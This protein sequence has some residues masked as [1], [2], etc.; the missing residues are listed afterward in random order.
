MQ[1][2]IA[3]SFDTLPNSLDLIV[4]QDASFLPT[5]ILAVIDTPKAPIP[6]DSTYH[7]DTIP[8]LTPINYTLFASKVRTDFSPLFPDVSNTSTP[9][10]SPPVREDR[11]TRSLLITLPVVLFPVPHPPSFSLLL[12]F[13]LG[14]HATC[15]PDK[16][17]GVA[18][19]RLGA[20]TLPGPSVP[21]SSSS[22]HMLSPHPPLERSPPSLIPPLVDD[23]IPHA[24]DLHTSTGLLATYLLPMPVIEE[25]PAVGPMVELLERIRELEDLMIFRD[26][27][28]GLWRNLL[29]IAPKD[30]QVYAIARVAFKVT[31]EATRRREEKRRRE[32]EE[33]D[34]KLAEKQEQ[35]KQDTEKQANP[36]Q[37]S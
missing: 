5:H 27:N 1:S 25:C 16:L 31:R 11:R 21:S 6:A 19:G 33:R 3:T 37:A 7:T 23:D 15:T 17:V 34:R 10:R 13:A 24:I 14:L 35:K 2:F 22:T 29:S 36:P 20:T 28:T 26:F 4:L 12:L 9:Y 18:P 32:Q 30:Q 8:I